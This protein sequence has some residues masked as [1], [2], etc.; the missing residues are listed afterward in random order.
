MAIVPAVLFIAI[1]GVRGVTELLILSQVVL[2]IQLSF[3]VFPLI[4]FTSNKKIMGNFV[5]KKMITVLSFLIALIIA[6]LNT[7]LI[8]SIF[9]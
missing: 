3:A 5:N 7:W 2:S 6:I 9:K 8:L 4:M 1:Y